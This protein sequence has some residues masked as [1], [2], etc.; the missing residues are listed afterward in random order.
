[1][2]W[3]KKAQAETNWKKILSIFGLSTILGL[4]SLW[5]IG[6]LDIKNLYFRKPEQVT[7]NLEQYQKSTQ[8]NISPIPQKVITQEPKEISEEKIIP[9]EKEIENVAEMIKRHEGKRNNLYFVNEV[10]HI[11][12][13]FNL[14]RKD[15]RAKLKQLNINIDDILR[16]K[17]K[18]TDE[19][20]YWLFKLDLEEA[21][22][23]AR[24]LLP[25]FGEQPKIVQNI[26]TDMAFNLGYSRLSGFKNFLNALVK[27][28][29]NKAAQEMINSRWYNQVENRAKELVS[30]MGEI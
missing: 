16:K 15:A 24:S 3:Y 20:I 22:K 28:D 12:I 11:G 23:N 25:N 18:L 1:M 9:Q 7:T 21:T 29:Y 2:N 30:I 4:A 27:K 6:L 8:S 26:L 17:I 14:T 10:P 19:Q 13:G 5:G